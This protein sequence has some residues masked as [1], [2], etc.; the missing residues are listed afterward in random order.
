[1]I[2]RAQR[3]TT[4]SRLT[5]GPDKMRTL[6]RVA[7]RPAGVTIVLAAVL[8]VVTLMA[9][10]SDLTGTFGAIASIWM[11]VHQVP[12]TVDDTTL[13]VLPIVP[14]AVMIWVAA[15]GCASAVDSGSER[16]WIARVAGAA[17]AG[18]FLI[19]LTS[20]A[21]VE[22]AS[23]VIPLSTPNVF[24]AV[25][26]TLGVHAVA[27][28]IG[29]GVALWSN[30]Q[31]WVPSWIVGAIRPALRALTALLGLGALAVLVS[32]LFA[33]STAGELIGRGEGIVGMTGLTLLSILYLPNIVIGAVV[34][35]MGATARIGEASVSLFGG[36]GGALPPLPVLAVVPDG[37]AGGL[38]ATLL[39]VPFAVG[40]FLG[41]DCGRKVAGQEA[42]LTVL[43]AAAAAGFVAAF[44]GLVAGGDLG[45]FGAVDLDWWLFGL[46]TFGWLVLPGAVTAVGVAWARA[47]R[48][49]GAESE[50]RDSEAVTETPAATEAIESAAEEVPA[51]AQDP[52]P[53]SS[54][55]VLEAE[56]VDDQ[57][58]AIGQAVN[59][60]TAVVD[61]VDAEVEE[62]DSAEGETP[63]SEDSADPEGALPRSRSTPSD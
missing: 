46:L 53:K 44:A 18:P 63:S 58:P 32:L 61:V 37:P 38:W 41:R 7:F 4:G 60:T 39:V 11:A 47:R 13:G 8:V 56:I 9:A 43:C 21:V 36:V 34:A 23:V 48:E 62:T 28:A 57:K 27:V 16:A 15:R 50:V 6:L 20:L 31:E 5:V 10:N 49:S 29:L 2:D 19:T 14:T 45:T 35:L 30:L 25:A 24:A 33:W 40:V 12:V 42:V 3:Q 17:L 1:M 54:N 51:I 52:A 26:W 22:D 59:E 55:R